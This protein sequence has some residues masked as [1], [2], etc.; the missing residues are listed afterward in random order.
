MSTHGRDLHAYFESEL[1]TLRELGAEFARAHPESAHLLSGTSSDPSVER[2]LQGTAFLTARIRKRMEDDLAEIAHPVI[3]Q[4]W[5]GWLRPVPALAIQAFSQ[6][7]PDGSTLRVAAGTRLRSI[8]ARLDDNSQ[9]MPC[10]FV[11]T[12]PVELPP[13]RIADAR[14]V[15]GGRH[16]ALVLGFTTTGEKT[17]AQ[18]A[19]E[20]FDRL[21]VHVNDADVPFA[22]ALVRHLAHPGED[23]GQGVV[24]EAGS[25]RRTL[26]RP[27]PVG[28][29]PE[30]S[31]FG[32]D[33]A[34]VGAARLLRE[35]FAFPQKHLFFELIGLRALTTLGDADKFT[36]TLPF[37]RPFADRHRVRTEH[38]V[39]GCTPIRNEFERAGH[40]FQRLPLK[41][42]YRIA[43]SG[44]PSDAIEVLDVV[45]VVGQRQGERA[46]TPYLPMSQVL[47][48]PSANSVAWFD[49]RLRADERKRSTSMWL[50]LS[51]P[52]RIDQDERLSPALICG[53]GQLPSQL[54]AGDITDAAGVASGVTSRNLAP[55]T[56][57]WSPPLANELLWRMLGHLTSAET[58]LRDVDGLR[59]LLTLHNFR[60]ASRDARDTEV[61]RRR[62][63][64]LRSIQT[65]PC[66][67]VVPVRSLLEPGQ[68]APPAARVA[69][70]G[71]EV[72]LVVDG[73]NLDGEGIAW[74]LGSALDRWLADSTTL[75]TFTRLVVREAGRQ[76]EEIAWPARLGERTLT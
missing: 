53:N 18:L 27:E 7:T 52:S 46:R 3:R 12:W 41:P 38:F 67:R 35:L 13:L 1:A 22:A 14:V 66:D 30:Q 62:M 6:R 50:V 68:T 36:I 72:H 44:R 33:L 56:P 55:P 59:S 60:V 40:P 9:P 73:A 76:F 24:V 47:G 51:P 42:E 39:L 28:F 25:Q 5:P 69:C 71:T 65:H 32:G 21:R 26:P 45:D 49:V 2:M 19:E 11:T 63:A 75:N 34:D 61:H 70:R 16:G 15:G 43:G 37:H 57:S 23:G 20:P 29:A 10:D 58:P 8:P 54:R 31:L 64:A 74:L 4:L 48:Q 17:L